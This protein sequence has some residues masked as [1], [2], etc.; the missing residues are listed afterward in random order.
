MAKR[1]KVGNPMALGV[2]S[3]LAFRQMHPYEI[4][5]ALKGW[6]K[7]RDLQIKWGSLYTVVGNLAKNDLITEVESVREGRRPERTVY[8]ITDTGRAELLD[9]TRELLSTAE[10]ETPRFRSGL[11]VMSVLSP[12]EVVTL[13]QQRLDA[14]GQAIAATLVEYDVPRLFLLEVEY[15]RAMLTAEAAWMR[16]LIAELESGTL[17]GID[18]WRQFHETGTAPED[19]LRLA[20]ESIKNP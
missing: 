2:L 13:L 1:R 10:P 14:V 12:D 4:A 18:D 6:G 20:E 3:V 7:D 11:S 17:P 5:S 15:D 16:S 8:R 19:I 9:W